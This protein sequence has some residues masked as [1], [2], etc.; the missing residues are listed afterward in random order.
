VTKALDNICFVVNARLGSSRLPGK[1]LKP[2]AGTT[3]FELAVDKIIH[4]K[5]PE[6]H[7]YLSLYD[8]AL[9]EIAHNKGIKV[10][11]RSEESV[12]QDNT[13]ETAFTLPEVFEWWEELKNE[14]EY[15]L[16]LNA[17]CPLLR[18]STLNS[19]IDEF[20]STPASG[21]FSVIEHRRFFY[22]QDS[23]I[24]NDY[25]GTEEMK[26]TF[27]TKFVEP[28]YSAAP[29][30]AGRLADIGEHIY[31]GTFTK[32]NDPPL[33]VVPTEEATDIDYQSEF[34]RAE[35]LYIE[36]QDAIWG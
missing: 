25:T 18:V 7:L 26:I 6:E 2:F 12:R 34:N 14:Y 36:A 29:L 22:R 35:G 19:F 11:H 9:K 33:W 16:L 17:C 10:Y 31:M 3:L 5:F 20:L 30:R 1:M 32:P 27:N 21:L 23:S 4:S 8:D 28:I 24:I 15:Y 13:P